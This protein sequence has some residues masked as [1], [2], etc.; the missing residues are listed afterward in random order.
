MTTPDEYLQQAWRIHQQGD[1][2]QAE[3][4]YRFVLQNVPNHGS[5]WCFLG[6]VLHDQKR[7]GEAIEAYEKSL[8]LQPDYPITLNNLGNSLRYAYEPEKAD[9]CFRRALALNPK[10]V[11]AYKNRG[12]L[13]VWMGNLDL[14]LECY[15]QALEISPN[16][17]ELH[18]NLGV[19]FL[20]QQDFARGWEEYR[21][22]WKCP[23]MPR[24]NYR[25]PI[26]TGQNLED[27]TLLLYTEQGLGDTL[28]FI[29]LAAL[30]KKQA[31]RVLVHGQ[32]VLTN[33]LKN[34]GGFDSWIP[35]SLPIN[36]PFDYH[37]SLI[38]LADQFQLTHESIP[39]QVPYIHAE[40]Y[41]IDHWR[42]W[43]ERLP[44]AKVRIGI[45]W[46]GN[47]DHQ[48]D[49]FRSFPIQCFESLS[50]LPDVQLISLQ[51]GYG[52]D[53]ANAWAGQSELIR[54]PENTDLSNGAFMDTAAILHQL[55]LIITSDTAIAHLAGA[56]GR[57]T[58]LLLSLVP[59]WRWALR[60][61]SSPWYPSMR[62]WRQ[63]QQGDWQDVFARVKSELE[64]RLGS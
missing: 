20:L 33:L 52:S 23:E 57:E 63:T 44:K 58:W 32:P 8:E 17:P 6:I 61:P 40:P 39:D 11:N 62:L 5:G 21:W 2:R 12:T 3:T 9:A 13:H 16:D 46:Q 10:Y 7:Y 56:M 36:E 24:P 30:A 31:K 38:D 22:R 50:H 53:Q 35:F 64:L 37:C 60:S 47:R 29:R 54:L 34:T 18:R 14:A 43:F 45:Q 25:Q 42:D 19:L 59:D 4:A 55:D 49:T 26:W 41:L 15:Q 51:Q 1:L 28:H 27:K 48:A